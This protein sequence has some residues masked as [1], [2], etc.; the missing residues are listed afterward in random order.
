MA[1]FGKVAFFSALA[2]ALG[3]C[4]AE[5]PEW[6]LK[7]T[8]L[9]RANTVVE[10]R[11]DLGLIKIGTGSQS[12]LRRGAVCGVYRGKNYIGDVVIVE[13]SKDKAVAMIKSDIKIEKGD[14][15]YITPAN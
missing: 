6:A 5:A 2:T 15:V 8:Y 13:S 4:F 3:T 7:T 9:N 14:A 1:N 10:V 11:E 12:N